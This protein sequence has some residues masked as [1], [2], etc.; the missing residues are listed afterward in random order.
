MAKKQWEAQA[1]EMEA[2]V[3][4]VEGGDKRDYASVEVSKKEL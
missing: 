4:E 3:E 1:K 2:I